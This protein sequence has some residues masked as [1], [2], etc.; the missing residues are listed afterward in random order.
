MLKNCHLHTKMDAQTITALFNEKKTRYNI[1]FEPKPEQMMIASA[2]NNGKHC[3]GFLPT[4]FGKT[5]CFVVNC[6]LNEN[7]S[8]TLVISPLLSLMDNQIQSLEKW[9][10]KAAKISADTNPDVQKGTLLSYLVLTCYSFIL[11]K[12]AESRDPDQ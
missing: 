4:G 1:D 5:L 6:I 9:N 2:I 8:I 7:P 11:M 10:L 3:L 12:L